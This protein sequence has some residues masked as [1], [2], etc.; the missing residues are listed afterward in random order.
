MRL[1]VAAGDHSVLVW[2]LLCGLSKAK[3]YLLNEPVSGEEAERIGL[4][5][6]CV[7]D[8]EVYKEA[9]KIAARLTQGAPSAIRLTKY[10]LNWLRT[11]GPHF[12]TSLA[13]EFMGF[14]GPDAQEGLRSLREKRQPRFQ[15]KS[16]L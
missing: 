16:P 5:S 2:P 13:L 6:R 1:G 7:E 14:L 12:D 15:K 9:L 3:Y 10:A 11:M 4:V 8:G